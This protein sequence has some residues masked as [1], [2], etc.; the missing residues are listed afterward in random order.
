[1]YGCVCFYT[2]F[3][4]IYSVQESGE[5]D[6]IQQ[7]TNE[8]VDP[9]IDITVHFHELDSNQTILCCTFGKPDRCPLHNR[10]AYTPRAS[11]A[12]VSIILYF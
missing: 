3:N 12:A 9:D 2:F 4:D 11:R 8:F 6:A 5:L 7:F 10:K 1:M